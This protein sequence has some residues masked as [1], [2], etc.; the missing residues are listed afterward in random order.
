MGVPR[1]GAR[2]SDGQPLR[3]RRGPGGAVAR[4]SAP[5]DGAGALAQ[6]QRALGIR[7]R[8][9]G[10]PAPGSLR[11]R[12]LGALRHRIDAL[13][14]ASQSHPGRTPVVPAELR[15]SDGMAQRKAAAA[16]RRRR[17]A[18]RRASKRG[19]RRG[20]SRRV[21]PVLARHHRPAGRRFGAGAG[22]LRVGSHGHV[23]PGAREA[24]QRSERDLVHVRHRDLADR[25]AGALAGARDHGPVRRVRPRRGLGPDSRSSER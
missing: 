22:G 10:R 15:D 14:R 6:P 2:R 18:R 23:D 5:A 13:R 25:L 1:A 16:L 24:G 19:T 11:R 4:V 20:T 9:E 12:D 3:G 21:H 17:L 7:P 8:R